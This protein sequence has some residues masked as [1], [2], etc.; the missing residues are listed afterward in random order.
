MAD[1]SILFARS[2]RKELETLSNSLIERI[3]KK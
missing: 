2:A 1:Y 3:L